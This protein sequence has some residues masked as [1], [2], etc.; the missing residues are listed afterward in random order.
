MPSNL[1]TSTSFWPYTDVPLQ[2]KSH[3]ETKI[4]RQISQQVFTILPTFSD[5]YQPIIQDET[6]S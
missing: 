4:K 5:L 3:D 1:N 2:E 6:I